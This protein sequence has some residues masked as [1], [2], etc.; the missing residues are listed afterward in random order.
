MDINEVNSIDDKQAK[1]VLDFF[2]KKAYDPNAYVNCSYDTVNVMVNGNNF[3]LFNFKRA[4]SFKEITRN[5]EFY[6]YV[7]SSTHWKDILKDMLECIANGGYVSYL[8]DA[9]H[10]LDEESSIEEALISIELNDI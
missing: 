5:S 4:C 3:A 9:K 6:D 10:L 1:D 2:A 8:P 7:M